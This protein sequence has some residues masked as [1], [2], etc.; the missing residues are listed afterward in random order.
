MPTASIPEASPIDFLARRLVSL[1]A[2][3]WDGPLPSP[4]DFLKTEKGVTAYEIVSVRENLRPDPRSRAAFRCWRVPVAEVP[5][6]A[7]IHEW[8]WSS[9]D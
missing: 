7:R 4:G 6:G 2:I 9:R 3:H 1:R 8:R 5:A